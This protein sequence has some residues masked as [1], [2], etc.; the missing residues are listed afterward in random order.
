MYPRRADAAAVATLTKVASHLLPTVATVGK[1]TMRYGRQAALAGPIAP[2]AKTG[3]AVAVPLAPTSPTSVTSALVD[4]ALASVNE[5]DLA[6]VS[7]S[8]DALLAKARV[9]VQPLRRV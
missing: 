8:A 9:P 1:A 3:A 4:E 5:M 7:N 2:T 6:A